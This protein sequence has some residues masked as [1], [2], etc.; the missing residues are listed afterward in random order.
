VP[1]LPDTVVNGRF[2]LVAAAARENLG[3]AIDMILIHNEKE[4]RGRQ[5]RAS[6]NRAIVVT[7][8][9]AWDRFV[10][11]TRHA[12]TSTD[13][14]WGSGLD[15]SNFGDLY[16]QRSAELLTAAGATEPFFWQ[17]LCLVA[18][19]NWSGVRMRCMETLTGDQPGQRSGL[20]FSQHLNQW[21]TVRNA[22]AHGSIRELLRQVN[23]PPK[24][25][26]PRILAAYTSASGKRYRLWESD[27]VGTASRHGEDRLR[28]ATIQS[29]CARGCLA[30]VIQV[31]D[32]LIVDICCAHGRAW[33]AEDLR[34]PA[35]WF[36]RRLPSPFRSATPDGHAHW[37]LWGGPKLNRRTD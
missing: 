2:G 9:G 18:A 36:Q 14:R 11:D 4:V 5:P 26:D 27:A 3:A 24:R 7:A 22:L 31:I 6:L 17:R 12:F 35:S 30:L 23:A 34:L 16:A 28:G 32:W 33:D 8:I 25:T 37:T 19:T 21:V 13:P 29:G 10:A 1:K 20:T 15:P